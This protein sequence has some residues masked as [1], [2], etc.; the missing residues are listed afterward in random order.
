MISFHVSNI[1]LIKIRERKEKKRNTVKEK[2]KKNTNT[3]KY[4]NFFCS[5]KTKN[6][7]YLKKSY[8]CRVM[9][10]FYTHF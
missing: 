1:H 10:D 8:A 6:K 5:N 2:E 4:V 3:T 9:V 7:K